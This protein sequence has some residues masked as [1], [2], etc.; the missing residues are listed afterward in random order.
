MNNTALPYW[1]TLAVVLAAAYGGFKA[2]QVQQSRYGSVAL[3]EISLPPLE[4]F[5][6]ATSTGEPFRSADMK[7]RVWVATF[8]FSTCSGS[9]SRLNANIKH[10]SSLDEIKD[11][12]WVS[13]TVDPETDTLAVL[14]AK[15]KELNADPERWLFCRGEFDYVKRIAHDIL[16]VGGV[17]LKGHND[18]AVVIDKQGEIADMFN[19]TSTSDSKRGVETLKKCL[20][21]P[22]NPE[23]P[24]PSSGAQ[25]VAA[26]ANDAP[27][28]AEAA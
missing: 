19:A 3:S 27:Q 6:L 12:T 28:S 17:S 8:F 2:Y 13:I 7:G 15:A 5:E 21:Q 18:Y 11:V 25:D 1:I 26:P 24:A 16:H 9:C 23:P 4:E 22:Y 14:R 10:L 20:A